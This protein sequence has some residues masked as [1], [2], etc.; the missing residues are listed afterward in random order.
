MSMFGHVARLPV[1]GVV[2]RKSSNV[3]EHHRHLAVEDQLRDVFHGNRFEANLINFAL[4]YETTFVGRNYVKCGK[5]FY[6]SP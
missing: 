2:R 4:F 5:L 3:T 6:N 1:G